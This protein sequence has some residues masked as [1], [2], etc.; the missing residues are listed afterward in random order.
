MHVHAMLV[1]G[2]QTP[3]LPLLVVGFWPLESVPL[4]VSVSVP[5]VLES[6]VLTLGTVPQASRATMELMM[7]K[8]AIRMI[9]RYHT[10][11]ARRSLFV[12]CEHP[13]RTPHTPHL[14]A[15]VCYPRRV[16]PPIDFYLDVLSP[17]VYIAE[18]RLRRLRERR[19]D[20]VV[21]YRP[22]LLAAVLKRC[23]QLGPA[24]IPAKRVF[25]FKDI[26][27]RCAEHDLPLV[28]PSSH[29]F[30]P[31]CALRAILAAAPD[32]RPDVT[33]AILRAGWAEGA[34]LGDPATII[35]ALDRAGLPGAALVARG[36]TPE[37]KAALAGE[38]EEAIARGVFGVPSFAVGDELLWGQDRLGDLERILDGRDPVDPQ[39]VAAI[40]TRPASA[41]RH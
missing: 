4:L 1:P 6:V 23:G 24:E 36:G 3:L 26:V 11:R 14:P 28:G 9:A 38:T 19:P 39:Q 22:I 8:G 33:A 13:R 21:R 25:T 16:A 32:Q 34:E 12:A 10:R 18:A 31:L 5:L 27:R 30:N 37:I 40:L 2:T 41:T 29:P 20:L 17:Y 15:E 7:A 35:A